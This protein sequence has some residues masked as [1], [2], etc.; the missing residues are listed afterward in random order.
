MN[1]YLLD[2]DT[3]NLRI[4]EIIN[5][6]G[7]L[8]YIG[9]DGKLLTQVRNILNVSLI[10]NKASETNYTMDLSKKYNISLPKFN[11]I[12][13]KNYNID[14][15]FTALRAK[16]NMNEDQIFLHERDDYVVLVPV[17]EQIPESLYIFSIIAPHLLILTLWHMLAVSLTLYLIRNINHFKNYQ[18]IDSITD[19]YKIIVNIPMGKHN[20]NFQERLVLCVW[21]IYSILFSVV[22]GSTMVSTLVV[23]KYYK[24]IDTIEELVKTNLTVYTT[25][26]E[27]NMVKNSL[28]GSD[29]DLLIKW[30]L[31]LTPIFR[32][33][34][35][36]I[37][38][39]LAL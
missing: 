36:R 23:P 5:N 21:I 10:L 9:Y 32:Q 22:F 34:Y 20:I 30:R 8:E 37:R 13:M 24:T 12:F 4:Q 39:I 14:I 18:L 28:T 2:V 7:G 11:E 26:F 33:T 6:K 15:I 27:Y 31:A 25:P 3:Y 16:A 29:V 1:V 19:T 17:G 35:I 38:T